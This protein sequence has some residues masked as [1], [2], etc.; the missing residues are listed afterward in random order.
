MGPQDNLIFI[1]NKIPRLFQVLSETEHHKP[2]R[3]FQLK[4]KPLGP[5]DFLKCLQNKTLG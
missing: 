2:L 1:Q 5:Q 3:F 4:I